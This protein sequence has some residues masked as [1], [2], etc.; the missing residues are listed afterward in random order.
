MSSPM[1]N[2]VL[3]VL[4][5]MAAQDAFSA[6]SLDCS[7]ELAACLRL[8]AAETAAFVDECGKLYPES[9]SGLDTA[10]ARWSI[11]KLRI[12]GVDAAMKPGSPDRVALGKKAAAYL[13]SVGSYEREIEC[14]GRMAVL[15]NKEPRIRSDFVNLPKDPLEPYM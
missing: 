1:R 15:K 5:A 7:K 9:K 2:L 8:A 3:T 4:L 6:D 11:R 13:K 12:A 10:L 14:T